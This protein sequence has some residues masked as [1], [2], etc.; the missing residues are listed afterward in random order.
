MTEDGEMWGQGSEGYFV[1][2]KEKLER[3][4]VRE[5]G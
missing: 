5:R 1:Q 3:E 2:K 4:S